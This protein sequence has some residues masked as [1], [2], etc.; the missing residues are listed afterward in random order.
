MD[1][2]ELTYA[3][4]LGPGWFESEPGIFRQLDVDESAQSGPPLRLVEESSAPL[5][6]G[7]D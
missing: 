3:A 2:P 4:A 6:A 1:E 7:S 5:S